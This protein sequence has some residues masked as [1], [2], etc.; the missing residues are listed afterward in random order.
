MYHKESVFNL[1]KSKNMQAQWKP[2]WEVT[3][4]A[5]VIIYKRQLGEGRPFCQFQALLAVADTLE[6]VSGAVI[7]LGA[8]RSFSCRVTSPPSSTNSSDDLSSGLQLERR[9][10]MFCGQMCLS[11][12]PSRGTKPRESPRPG[13]G[14]SFALSRLSALGPAP[15]RPQ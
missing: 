6:W 10:G 4:G 11:N 13:A 14:R 2:H 5:D 7:S 15:Q 9:Q 12:T 1:E 8:S 3:N